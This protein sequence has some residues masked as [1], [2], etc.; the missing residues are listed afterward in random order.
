MSKLQAHGFALDT[1]FV[2]APCCTFRATE[3]HARRVRSQA[4][5]AFRLAYLRNRYKGW[6]W[7][8]I[9]ERH[10]GGGSRAA[11]T[12]ENTRSLLRVSQSMN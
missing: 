1:P 9:A 12:N 8:R 2:G 11:P 5:R 3:E 6:Q 7:G 10:F 4:V